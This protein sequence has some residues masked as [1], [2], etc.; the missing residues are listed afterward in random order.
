MNFAILQ[1]QVAQIPFNVVD[2]NGNPA[3]PSSLSAVIDNYD[4]AYIAL[5]N[6]N[7]SQNSGNLDFGP[8]QFPAPGGVTTVTINFSGQSL[9]GTAL[10]PNSIQIDLDGAT[11]PPQATQIEIGTPQIMPS[12]GPDPGSATIKIV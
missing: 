8:K 6:L 2:S 3:T 10:P 5:R 9:D 4:A 11:P 7:S 1:G 12:I